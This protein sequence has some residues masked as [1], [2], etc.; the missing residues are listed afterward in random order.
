MRAVMVWLTAKAA[1]NPDIWWRHIT[2]TAA[3]CEEIGATSLPSGHESVRRAIK[4]LAERGHVEIR[5]MARHIEVRLAPTHRPVS[6]EQSST[7]NES[8]LAERFELVDL[9][10]HALAE[11]AP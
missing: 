2:V 4:T 1:S 11:D 8:A 6:A 3:V 5:Q 10:R 9:L 7:L